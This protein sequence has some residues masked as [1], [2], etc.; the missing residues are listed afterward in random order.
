MS[1]HYE[2]PQFERQPSSDDH[3]G[4][5]VETKGIPQALRYVAKCRCGWR[6]PLLSAAGLAGAAW[7]EHV[8]LVTGSF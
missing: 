6:S 5:T 7:D 2:D 3:S 1:M 4:Y 8:A